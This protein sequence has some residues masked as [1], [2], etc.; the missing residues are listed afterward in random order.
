MKSFIIFVEKGGSDY[1]K[2]TNFSQ[3]GVGTRISGAVETLDQGP[4][5]VGWRS[6]PILTQTPPDFTKAGWACEHPRGFSCLCGA[7]RLGA[8][9]KAN[10][11]GSC[12]TPDRRPERHSKPAPLKNHFVFPIR[13]PALITYHPN[14]QINELKATLLEKGSRRRE[15]S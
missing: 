10:E 7:D 3:S 14:G 6:Q 15:G 1:S 11:R 4:W 9:G 13:T 2:G 5:T 12:N 8:E